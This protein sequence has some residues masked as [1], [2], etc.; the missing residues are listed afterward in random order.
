M[1]PCTPTAWNLIWLAILAA[2]FVF[3][4]CCEAAIFFL[5]G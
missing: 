1:T 2:V 5:F 4:I 3:G